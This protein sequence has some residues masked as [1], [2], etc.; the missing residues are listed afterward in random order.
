[1]G[2]SRN[3]SQKAGLALVWSLGLFLGLGCGGESA[4][5][6]SS[7]PLE[8]QQTGGEQFVG[9]ATTIVGFLDPFGNLL[10]QVTYVKQVVIVVRPPAQAGGLVE[11]NPFNLAILPNPP[12]DA[13]SEGAL[14]LQSAVGFFDPTDGQEFLFQYWT[15]TLNGTALSGTLTNNHATEALTLNFLNTPREL[16]PGIVIVWPNAI[17]NGTTL[18]GTAD[19]NQVAL[20][21]QGN[22]VSG[23]R[24]FVSDITAVR[25]LPQPQP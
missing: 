16:A 9:S 20:R 12:T 11:G 14:S 21:I 1:M 24:P 13:S 18:Q 6:E 22:V 2:L 4:R 10:G 8:A 5:Q 25:V 15:F 17:A 7:A 23:D 19:A 3:A